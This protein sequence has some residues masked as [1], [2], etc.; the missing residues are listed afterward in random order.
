M[1]FLRNTVNYFTSNRAVMKAGHLVH[2]AGATLAHRLSKHN[3]NIK[4][5]QA[6]GADVG[7]FL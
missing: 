2:R 5:K 6:V 7:F 1:S 3:M 4:L